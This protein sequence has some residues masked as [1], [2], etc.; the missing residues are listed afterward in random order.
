M[1]KSSA[2]KSKLLYDIINKSNGF[3]NCPIEEGFRSRMNVVFRVGG[4]GGNDALEREFLKGAEQRGMV[5]LKGH[6][7]VGGVR[8]SLYNAVTLQDTTTLADYMIEFLA[9]HKQ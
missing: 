2:Q 8:A 4:P 6:R 7:S 5:Q 1:E 3:Y 9:S